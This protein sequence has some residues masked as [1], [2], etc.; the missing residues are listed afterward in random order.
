MDDL[1]LGQPDP[2]QNPPVEEA[3]NVPAEEVV[4]ENEKKNDDV[5]DPNVGVVETPPTPIVE[6]T[7]IEQPVNPDASFN[8]EP[9]HG[10]GLVV[11]VANPNGKVCDVCKGVGKI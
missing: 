7:P 11:S 3:P 2:T 8:C 1:Q 9:C 5:V 10:S 4:T 6:P